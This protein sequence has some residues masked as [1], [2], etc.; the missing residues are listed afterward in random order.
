MSNW[1]KFIKR[2]KGKVK[3]KKVHRT[4]LTKSSPSETI[5]NRSLAGYTESG[6]AHLDKCTITRATTW[7][8][9]TPIALVTQHSVVSVHSFIFFFF[10]STSDKQ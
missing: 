8:K 5:D 6:E 7:D 4:R 3:A 2:R 1:R 9:P 10:S